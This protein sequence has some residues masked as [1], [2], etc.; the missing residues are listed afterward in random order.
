MMEEIEMNLVVEGVRDVRVIA[1]DVEF[2]S[3]LVGS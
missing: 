2:P 1:V 3:L